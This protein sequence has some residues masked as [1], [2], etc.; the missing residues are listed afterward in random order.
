MHYAVFSFIQRSPSALPPPPPPHNGKACQ[1]LFPLIVVGLLKLNRSNSENCIADEIFPLDPITGAFWH[2]SFSGQIKD[3]SAGDSPSPPCR[4]SV[5]SM[6]MYTD[7]MSTGLKCVVVWLTSSVSRL[8][9]RFNTL[10]SRSLLDVLLSP[11]A[12]SVMAPR[13]T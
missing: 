7:L 11:S 5:C 1:R 9:H 10:W 3:R 8:H 4:P 2:S 13:F 6:H 12:K